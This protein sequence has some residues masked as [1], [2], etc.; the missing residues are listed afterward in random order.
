MSDTTTRDNTKDE[1]KEGK[2]T[3][4]RRK[5]QVLA[6]RLDT[7]LRTIADTLENSEKK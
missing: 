4:K 7:L 1:Q 3:Q 5:N 2:K 6:I